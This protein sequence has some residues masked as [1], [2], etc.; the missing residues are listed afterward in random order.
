MA[1]C[2]AVWTCRLGLGILQAAAFFDHRLPEAFAGYRRERTRY[3][4]EYPT[5]CSPQAWATGAPLQIL[6]TMLGMEP[7][8][9][10]LLVNPHLPERFGWLQLLDVPGVWGR[11][12]A[13]G[14]GMV[15]VDLERLDPLL[16]GVVAATVVGAEVAES[17]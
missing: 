11:A 2:H 3:P 8:A 13:F 10:Q 6:R 9:G 16:L 15:E 1:G 7:V 5:A 17:A 4:V 14:R 12:D